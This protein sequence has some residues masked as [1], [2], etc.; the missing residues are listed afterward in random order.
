MSSR[1]LKIALGVSVAINVF[2][3]AIG[4]TVLVRQD[5]LEDRIDAHRRQVRERVRGQLRASALAGRPDFET[6]RSK[7]RE[8]IALARSDRFDPAEVRRLLEESR[9]AELRGRARLESD[10][11]GV[12]ETLEPDD[13]A[14]LH[15]LISRRFQDMLDRGLVAE[16][17]RLYRRG[18]LN[19]E[20]PSI[21]TV[22]YRHVWEYLTKRINYNQMIARATAATR[23]LAK[24]QMTWLRRYPGVQFFNA[25]GAGKGP[26][27]ECLEHLRKTVRPVGKSGVIIKSAGAGRPANNNSHNGPG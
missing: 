20:M 14:A 21:R 26:E 11:V 13:R 5:Q 25:P 12:L 7:R 23:Q 22:G 8:A 27:T 18:D 3:L 15:D 17:E 4:A 6:A 19:P 9:T 10:A 2:A 1:A 16:V 24:R